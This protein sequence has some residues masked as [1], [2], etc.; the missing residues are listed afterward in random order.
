M[1]IN[2]LNTFLSFDLSASLVIQCFNHDDEK[3]LFAQEVPVSDIFG[4]SFALLVLLSLDARASILLPELQWNLFDGLE[5]LFIAFSLNHVDASVTNSSA[6]LCFPLLNLLT[7]L[8]DCLRSICRAK[9]NVVVNKFRA[10]LFASILSKTHPLPL[11]DLIDSSSRVSSRWWMMERHCGIF[12]HRKSL[13][14]LL[15]RCTHTASGGF[16]EACVG[17]KKK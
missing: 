4:N 9:T 6:L 16:E 15:D 13:V 14:W 2:R 7:Y 8:N 11:N 17:E 3:F 10:N 12:R 5:S 1:W